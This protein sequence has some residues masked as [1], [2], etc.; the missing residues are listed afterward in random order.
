LD[1]S[2]DKTPHCYHLVTFKSASRVA[3]F[4]GNPGST[5]PATLGQA[6]V[7]ITNHVLDLFLL[8]AMFEP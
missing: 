8:H 5:L 6:G 7:E 2:D 1:T 4:C 3:A